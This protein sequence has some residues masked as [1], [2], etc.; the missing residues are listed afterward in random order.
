MIEQGYVSYWTLSSE[1]KQ[2]VREA[3]N[4]FCRKDIVRV[5]T[6]RSTIMVYPTVCIVNKQTG[7][8]HRVTDFTEDLI[9]GT[10]DE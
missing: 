2:G 5:D 3:M 6:E 10:P 4:K 8:S 7:D 9:S 1:L